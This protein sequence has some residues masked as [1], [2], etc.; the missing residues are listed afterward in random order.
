[1]WKIVGNILIEAHLSPAKAAHGK[2]LWS[3]HFLHS[4]SENIY[5]AL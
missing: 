1:M 5:Q 4:D 2:T 3:V